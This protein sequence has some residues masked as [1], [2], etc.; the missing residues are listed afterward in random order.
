M[1]NSLIPTI[2]TWMELEKEINGLQK[3]MKEL[4]LSKKKVN[5][6]LSEIM[7]KNELDC[8]DVTSGQIRYTKNKVKKGINQAYLMDV[9]EKYHNNNKD[10][11]KK[12]CD[13]IQENRKVE[14]KEKI[15]FKK[16]N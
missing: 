10:E 4:K 13:Y 8:I 11:A 14:E 3:K 9:L 15:H 12:I 7:K 1:E 6:E 5:E 2:K 16:I